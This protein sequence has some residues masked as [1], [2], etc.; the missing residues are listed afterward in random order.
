MLLRI[1]LLTLALVVAHQIVRYVRSV[2]GRSRNLDGRRAPIRGG[3]V[4]DVD[5]TEEPGKD[6]RKAD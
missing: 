4:V 3:R 2:A 6:S 1:L 5:F